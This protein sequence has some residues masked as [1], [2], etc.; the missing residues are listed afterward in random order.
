MLKTSG[1]LQYIRFEQHYRWLPP[2]LT[3]KKVLRFTRI[4]QVVLAVAGGSGPLDPP[5]SAAPETT[6]SS[7]VCC[8]VWIRT[9]A[10]SKLCIRWARCKLGYRAPERTHQATELVRNR[11][12][13]PG[14]RHQ[15]RLVVYTQNISGVKCTPLSGRYGEIGYQYKL[16]GSAKDVCSS[17]KMSSASG[18]FVSGPRWGL[19]PHTPAI[20]SRSRHS[21]PPFCSPNFKLLPTPLHAVFTVVK[22][23]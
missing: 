23:T 1:R 20:G 11:I 22:Q 4:S 19:W 6:V 10:A 7:P 5:A 16:Q 17:S 12:T 13:P 14:E 3:T 21:S 9:L 15:R 18:G 8:C 2:P